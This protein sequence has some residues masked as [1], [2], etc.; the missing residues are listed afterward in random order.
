[1]HGLSLDLVHQHPVPANCEE[2]SIHL[3][4]V[5]LCSTY[6]QYDNLPDNSYYN[7]NIIIVYEMSL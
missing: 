7:Y 5:F 4:A 2:L 3:K 6:K 1:M